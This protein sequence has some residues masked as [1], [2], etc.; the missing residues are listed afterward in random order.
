MIWSVVQVTA[1]DKSFVAVLAVGVVE[2][3]R[4]MVNGKLPTAV[5]VP[6]IT[7][8]EL[9]SV[10]PGGNAPSCTIH[11]NGAEPLFSCNVWE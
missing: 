11:V 5:G 1:I 9:L 10:S 3:V 7:P 8:L 6:L 2:S 4:S